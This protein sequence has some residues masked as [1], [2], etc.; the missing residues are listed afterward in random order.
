MLKS[1]IKNALNFTVKK[2]F[3]WKLASPISKFG[4][5]LHWQREHY[6]D[7]IHLKGLAAMPSDSVLMS[8]IRKLTV[9]HGPFEGMKYPSANAAGS[10]FYPKI[11]GSYEKEL[12]E[13]VNEIC[14]TKYTEIVDV[15]CAEGYYAVGLAMRIPGTRVFAYDID[16]RARQLCTEM[17]TLN[18]VKD[19]VNIKSFC[20]SDELSKISFAGR[21]LIVCDCEGYEMELFN[22][23][24]MRNLLKCDI[25]LETHDVNDI[26]ITTRLHELFSKTHDVIVVKSIDDI[27]KAKT[28]NYPE[29]AGLTLELKKELFAETRR[30]VME[31]FFVKARI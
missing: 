1:I 16:E 11:I 31:W 14:E 29:S 24:V 9:L 12:H 25:L 22:D 19:R 10:S 7:S 27:E 21:G 4:Y 13:I 3:L 15:G 30:S 17:A 5:F 26:N 2:N 28:Y 20:T 18:K 23:E 6:L 8:A